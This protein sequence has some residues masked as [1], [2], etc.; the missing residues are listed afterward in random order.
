VTRPRTPTGNAPPVARTSRLMPGE[1]DLRGSAAM[2]VGLQRIA[3]ADSVSRSR[4]H[5]GP[6]LGGRCACLGR[7]PGSV[8]GQPS[9][10]RRASELTPPKMTRA[11]YRRQRREERKLARNPGTHDP[12]ASSPGA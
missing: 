1:D 10:A 11:D 8:A 4:C 2:R 6:M 5:D 9:A 7:N 3:G 12:R